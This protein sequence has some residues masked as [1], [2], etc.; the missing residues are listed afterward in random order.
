MSGRTPSPTPSSTPMLRRT[1]VWASAL[2]GAI[3]VVG[4]VLGAIFAGTPGLWGAVIGTVIG[5]VFMALT[6]TSILFANRFAGGASFAG[7]F[8]GVVLGGWLVKFIVFLIIANLLRDAS[9][10]NHLTLFVCII[11]SV[12][13]SLVVDVLVVMSS[14]MPYVSDIELPGDR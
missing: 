1:L 3:L 14:R 10:L 12:L 8:F 4:G 13:A 5:L 2:C 6:A 7:V 11:A 9:W